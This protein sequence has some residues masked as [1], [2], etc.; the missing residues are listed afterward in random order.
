MNTF[1]HVVT[2]SGG[3]FLCS[4]ASAQPSQSST[5]DPPLSKA[6]SMQLSQDMSP[7]ARSQLATREAHAAYKEAMSACKSMEQAE[8]KGCAAEA[9]KNLNDDL[10][11]AKEIRTSGANMGGT[12]SGGASS[13]SSV[14]GANDLSSAGDSGASAGSGM[15]GTGSMGGTGMQDGMRGDMQGGMRDARQGGQQMDGMKGGMS[16]DSSQA[17]PPPVTAA[18][19][20]QFV[21]SFT[22]QAQYNLSKREANAAYKEA[23]K[24]CK[25]M[26]RSERS[27]CTKEARATLQQD[28]SYAKRQMQESSGASGTSGMGTSGSD[29]GMPGSGN[30]SGS[31]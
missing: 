20:Q 12:G 11:Y 23:L 4:L 7:K 22:P 14:S 9:K 27:A 13:G 18:E 17:S 8:R 5:G 28:L 31:K 16:N 15:S 21:Q 26:E 2:L 19:K 10:K 30:S 29:S 24:E 3:V 25:A 1:L 6:E